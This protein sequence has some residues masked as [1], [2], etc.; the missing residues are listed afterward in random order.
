VEEIIETLELRGVRVTWSSPVHQRF[1]PTSSRYPILENVVN[2]IALALGLSLPL[3]VAFV[4]ACSESAAHPVPLG[5]C[6]A[7][8]GCNPF[9]G[10]PVSG[11][12]SPVAP[13]ADAAVD[14]ATPSD[15]STTPDTTPPADAPAG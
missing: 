3:L 13:G 9:I 4:A 15:A 8:P 6:T 1:W 12:G 2:R 14:Q 11:G 5:D 7:A 10:Q